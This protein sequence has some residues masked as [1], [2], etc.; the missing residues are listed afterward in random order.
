MTAV[1]VAHLPD[2]SFIPDLL[3]KLAVYLSR[4][5]LRRTTDIG[6]KELSR[7]ECRIAH[8]ALER[9]RK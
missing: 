2:R 7:N 5:P 1:A 8:S 9:F 6:P 4:N 3:R